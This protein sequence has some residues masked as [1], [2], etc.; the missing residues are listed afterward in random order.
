M[1]TAAVATMVFPVKGD[2]EGHRG[3]FINWS[4]GH[5]RHDTSS[6]LNVMFEAEQLPTCVADLDA[7]LTQVNAGARVSDVH[8]QRSVKAKDVAP[9][10]LHDDRTSGTSTRMKDFQTVA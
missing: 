3:R 5:E 7:L 10:E 1:T 6:R 2:G 9:T 8:V 4:R